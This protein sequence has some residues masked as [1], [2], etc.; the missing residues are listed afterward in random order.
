MSHPAGPTSIRTG[1]VENGSAGWGRSGWSVNQIDTA[2]IRTAN[3]TP[4][5]T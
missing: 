3:A 2:V 5:T 4:T 1:S